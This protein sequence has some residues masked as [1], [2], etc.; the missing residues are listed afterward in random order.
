MESYVY[1]YDERI[2][3]ID[4]IE[5]SMWGND[6]VLNYSALGKDTIGIDIPDLYDNMEPKRGGLIDP[7]LGTTDN[8]INCATCGLKTEF[9]PGHFAHITLAEP[10]F[11]IGHIHKIKKILS[12]ICLKCS[13][14]LLDKHK[15]DTEILDMLKNKKG[16][17]RFNEIRNLT[18]NV[19]YCQR[20]N[21]GCGTPVS[22]IKLDIKKKTASI[23]IF[24]INTITTPGTGSG[25]FAGKT[26]IKQNI[27]PEDCWNILRNI[28]DIDC[29]IM[30]IDPIK[31]RPE[32]MIYKNFPVAP[33]TVRPSSKTDIRGSSTLD[34]DLTHKT[35]DIVKSNK[36]IKKYKESLS[37]RTSKYTKDHI[38]LLQYHIYTYLD[39]D[40]MTMPR[41]LQRGKVIKGLVSRIKGKTGRIRG[42]LMGKRVNF[43]A[44]TVITPDPILDINQLG[45]PIKMAKTLTFP[46]IVTP[47]NIDRLSELVK[48]GR[49]SYPGANF[50]IKTSGIGYGQIPQFDLRYSKNV[51]LRYGDI[52]ER[53]LVND[54][55]VL[56]NRQPT[57]HKLSMM[58]HRIKVIDNPAYKTLR[59]NLAVCEPYNADFD[60]DEMN[61]FIPQSIQSMMELEDI[62]NAKLQFISPRLSTPIIGTIQDGLLGA[63]NLTNP[64]TKINW[65][66][67]MNIMTNTD[68][69]DYSII[70]KNKIYTGSELFSMVI[71][72][73]VNL[74]ARGVV[75]E[76]GILKSGRLT[77][78]QL[79]PKQNNSIVHLVWNEYGP[80][81][82]KKFVDDSQRL[83]NNFNLYHGFSV[84]I[85]DM[86]IPE[87]LEKDLHIAMETTKL[88][89][90]HLVTD[91]ENNPDIQTP[92]DF[93]KSI[94]AELNAFRPNTVDKF[95]I[96]N[97]KDTN[98]FIIMLKSGSKG[99]PENIGQMGGCLA[100]QNV[101]GKRI[102]KKVNGRSLPYYRQ[103]D[104]SAPA[105][106]FIEQSFLN[107]LSPK[108]FIQHNMTS[109]EGLIDT[110]IKSVTGD[111]P[112]LI[113]ENGKTKRLLI[114]DW[115]DNY[116]D[117]NA[118]VVEHHKERDMELL[119]LESDAY[120]PTSD[121][122]GNVSWGKIKA[123]T[124]HDPGKELYKITTHGGRDVIVT[125]SKS[126]LIW[127]DKMKQF[128]RTSTP[129]VKIGDYVP[130]TMKLTEPP[131]IQNHAN[132]Y[133]FGNII[134]N[135]KSGTELGEILTNTKMDDIN[136]I[137]SL[138]PEEV[139]NAPVDFVIGV[140][141]GYISE[142]GNIT[143]KSIVIENQCGGIIDGIQTLCSR[144]GIYSEIHD[145]TLLIKGIWATIFAKKIT[146]SNDNKNKQLQQLILIKPSENMII[147]NDVV[148]DKIVDIQK[149]E[150]SLYPKVYDLTIP[151]TLNFGLANG[152]HVVDTAESGYVQRKLIKALED[153]GVQYDG[154][155]RAQNGVIY[156]FAY[157]DSGVDTVKQ[158]EH[159][160]LLISIS[161]SE[162]KER[163]KFS[164]SEIKKYSGYSKL[165]NQHYKDIIDMRDVMRESIRKR[166]MDYTNIEDT[167]K[168]PVNFNRIISNMKAEKMK[169][170]KSLDPSYVLEKLQS[171]LEYDQTQMSCMDPE[172]KK[173]KQS[174]KYQDEMLAK[175]LLKFAFYEY[176]SPKICI[177][178]LNMTKEKFD[179]IC[180]EIVK[181][182][183]D[184]IVEPGEMA[185]ILA[186]QSIGEPVKCSWCGE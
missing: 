28:S 1:L 13:K 98:N 75:I 136:I 29:M 54:D 145:S 40:S 140:L 42:S 90:D 135:R 84:G 14:V 53:H 27:S 83:V 39:N 171:M 122:L 44:R 131:V 179:E 126:L 12:S 183:N 86:N 99:G 94:N 78:G 50:V 120:I 10:V 68:I 18:K 153:L 123:I 64:K 144:L 161:N 23:S 55:V 34:D 88:K 26:T 118:D 97:M 119:N 46:E 92:E 111:T 43:S 112:I 149:I 184:S 134:L 24:A 16:K 121:E 104:D 124:R 7:R 108:S 113:M 79:G 20:V 35:A 167:F 32:M 128:V 115:I 62:A 45:V 186:A 130:V 8:Y 152:L 162:I 31:S 143:K 81:G 146:L 139:Y 25:T 170:G 163:Y 69:D 51:E 57:L 165:N 178:E 11:H 133:G 147:Q 116:I 67:A 9:C 80:D 127:N 155:V 103:N 96:S 41:S 37:D 60:G 173:N 19:R 100:Q 65:K 95:V 93:E 182:Y 61:I 181:E 38:N 168:L 106:G 151:S 150:V 175:T 21:Y 169:S 89:V 47:Y 176:L 58:G 76:N 109:R 180:K 3:P 63:Y 148:L 142:L 73:K 107:G 129:E 71:P 110:A 77:K 85:G 22:K 56:L 177:K 114:G 158:Y 36:R 91:L 154:S 157:G 2:K 138:M 87:K 156:E 72:N 48:A 172:D 174:L 33:V 185:G 159:K 132:I 30:G 49:D 15:T 137:Y 141:D 164:D 5:F 105:R 70:K 117:N 125:E 101:E 66:N 160:L 74:N 6:E 166:T 52:V 4:K 82:A 102:P 59:L 17:A